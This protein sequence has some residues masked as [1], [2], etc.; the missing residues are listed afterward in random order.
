MR[1]LKAYGV[2]PRRASRPLEPDYEDG[3]KQ[4]MVWIKIFI[5]DNRRARAFR[6]LCG[7]MV[8]LGCKPPRKKTLHKTL[9]HCG[10][11]P[12]PVP[13]RSSSRLSPRTLHRKASAAYGVKPE[14]GL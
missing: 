7:N 4:T 8:A 2:K 13:K 12:E 9:F 5:P 14:K 11:V 1:S 3:D 10:L 6:E